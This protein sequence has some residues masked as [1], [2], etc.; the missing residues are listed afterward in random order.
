MQNKDWW[1][2]TELNYARLSDRQS[3]KVLWQGEESKATIRWRFFFF[4]CPLA[5]GMHFVW[6]GV[7]GASWHHYLAGFLFDTTSFRFLSPPKEITNRASTSKPS[8]SPRERKK[9]TRA[10]MLRST[11]EYVHQI[12]STYLVPPVGPFHGLSPTHR[13]LI[14]PCKTEISLFH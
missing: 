3:H 2:Q 14:P 13:P 6:D 1:Y 5:F 10:S 7:M 12:F 11:Q 4:F 8:L 9:G